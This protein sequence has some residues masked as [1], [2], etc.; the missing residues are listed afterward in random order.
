MAL[1]QRAVQQRNA[2]L[3]HGTAGESANYP[4]WTPAFYGPLGTPIRQGRSGISEGDLLGAAK[5]RE[6]EV[7]AENPARPRL[8]GLV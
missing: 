1:A 4:E 6:L 3:I 2:F 8:S 7:A 5:L